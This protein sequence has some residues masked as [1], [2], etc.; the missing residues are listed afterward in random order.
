M[1][2]QD[3]AYTI[4]PITEATREAFHQVDQAAFFFDETQE[5]DEA[6]ESLDLSRCF[7]A[8]PT[9]TA[10]FAGVYGSYDLAITIPAAGGGPQAV[11]MAGLTWVGVHPDERRRGVMSQ[12]IRHHF[13]EVRRQGVALSGLHASEPAIYG[14]FGYGVASLDAYLGL[15]RGDTLRA[16]ALDAAAADVRTRVVALAG[17]GVADRVH[18]M[19]VALSE[20]LMG[21]VTRTERQARAMSRDFL[22]ARRGSEPTQV[23]LAE[24]DGEDVGYALFRR[25]SK[26]EEGRPQGALTS[27]EMM[28]ADSAALLALARR[29]LD[30]DLTTSVT[31]KGRT[32]DDPVLWWAGG[33]RG[34]SVEIYDGTWLRLVEVG[35]A[36]A[37]RG[38]ATPV[39]V[40]IAVDDPFCPWNEGRWRLRCDG[41]GKVAT[42]E[43]TEDTAGLRLPVQVLGSAYCG[44]RTI[45]A[46]Q[47]DGT[48][49]E[50]LP[51]SVAA[52]SAAM[53]TPRQPA[54]SIPF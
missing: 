32:L 7:A 16:P 42:C 8:T 14:R 33:P 9:G 49:A 31:L 2:G 52:L 44:L 37:Q 46:Q 38:Y 45:A 40:V 48:V 39:D 6:L 23:L 11:P 50:V 5:T 21:A 18:R 47:A 1:A 54:A 26:W 25:A 12:M 35:A 10:P 34:A 41:P 15:S 22:P 3:T 13:H 53:A 36:L 30:F 17:E 27:R 24:R 51:G 19:H 4:V 20:A 28:A 43:R 29:L